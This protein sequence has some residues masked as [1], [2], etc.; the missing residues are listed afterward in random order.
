MAYDRLFS[1]FTIKNL[2]IK[3]RI[4]QL[5]V[6]TL[7]GDDGEGFVSSRHHQFYGNIA[8]GGVGMMQLEAM[9]LNKE[10]IGSVPILSISDDKYIDKL[11]ALV[12]KIHSYGV[13]FTAQLIYYL[14]IT[15][16]HHQEPDELTKDEISQIIDYF[17]NGALRCKKV[18]FDGVDFHAAH[19]YTLASFLSLRANKRK[20]EYGGSTEKR[21]KIMG[22]IIKGARQLVG[23][24]YLLGCRMNAEDFVAGGNTLMHTRVL[25]KKFEEW[26]LDI[27]GISAGGRYEDGDFYRGY[28]GRRCMPTDEMVDCCNIYLCADLKRHTTIP[29]IASGKIRNALHGE[30]ILER[31]D[32]DLVGYARPFIVD[33]EWPRKVKDGSEEE[34]K[35]C[36]Y[37][38]N[39]IDKLRYLMPLDC[40]KWPDF[41]KE[42]SKSESLYKLV[43]KGYN[44]QMEFAKNIDGH[45]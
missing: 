1:P 5:P 27:I 42:Q 22:K 6:V 14:K 12:D 26:G 15:N 25:V 45:E 18:G 41:K 28:S 13:V 36:I 11:K 32:A 38:N 44:Y 37:C 31:R 21:A 7:M 40:V 29:L 3:N 24:N 17:V 20:D 39:C 30:E 10:P 8:K 16:G 19:E 2:T 9:R 33:P 43:K 34:I 23:N 35:R 4:V